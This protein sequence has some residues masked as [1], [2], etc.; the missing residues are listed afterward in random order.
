M[1]L[2]SILRP[3]ILKMQPYSSARDE[4]SGHEALFL[5]ANENP[6]GTLNRYPDPYQKALKNKISQIKDIDSDCIFIG[7]GSDEI[8]DLTLRLF[9]TP[10]KDSILICPPTYGMYEVCATTNDVFVEKIPLTDDFQLDSPRIL[11]SNAKILFI[12]SPNNP[13][14][15]TIENLDNLLSKFSG[16]VF[17]DEAYIDFSTS[18]SY[19]NKIAQ[20]PNLIISQTLSKAWGQA[21]IRIGI[22]Y[23]SPEIIHYFNKV[24]PPYNVSELNQNAALE[25]LSHSEVFHKNIHTL[26]QEREKLIKA[27]LKLS[28]VKKIYPTDANF[29]LVQFENAEN[30]Y[31]YLVDQSVITRLRS[32]VVKDTLRITVGTPAENEILLHHLKN[33]SS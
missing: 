15:N 3:N 23:S 26:I 1:N 11:L 17:L 29:I 2:E 27:L 4:F 32:A 6:F 22:G 13:T 31:K 24:K 20:F 30:V 10:G 25:V 19:I 28:I 14:G 9:C 5:D 12:C 21:A 18:E 7:N 33:L 8:I 16:I